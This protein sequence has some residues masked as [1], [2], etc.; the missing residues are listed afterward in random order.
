LAV[1]SSNLLVTDGGEAFSL[2]LIGGNYVESLLR[3]IMVAS[4]PEI[5]S[6]LWPDR[7]SVKKILNS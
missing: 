6:S 1:F 3:Q 2:R 7:A 5:D 4:G